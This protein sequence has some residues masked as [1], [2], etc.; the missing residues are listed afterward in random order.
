MVYRAGGG[1]G[2]VRSL[3]GVNHHT[4]PVLVA[5]LVVLVEYLGSS[6]TLLMEGAWPRERLLQLR[7]LRPIPEEAALERRGREEL[8]SSGEL[9]FVR[10][11]QARERGGGELVIT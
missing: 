3:M 6:M 1:I 4:L 8:H 11:L 10:D 9:S 2:C 5:S 7:P